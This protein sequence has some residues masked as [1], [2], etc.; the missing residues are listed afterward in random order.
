[1]NEGSVCAEVVHVGQ[2]VPCMVLQVDD[3]KKEG[4]AHKRVWLSLRLSRMY[5]GLSLD[6][7][8]D[9]MVLTAQVKSVEDHGYILYFGVSTFSGFMP[10]AGKETVKIESGQL[11]QCVVKGID[12][13]RSIIH[14]SSDE[15]LISK[16]IIKDLK[17]LS[18]DHLIPGM[19]MSARVHSV[20][21]N[22]VMLSFLTYFTGT[23]DIFNLS[24][25]FPSGNWKDDYSKN[26]KVNARILFV[27][28][29]TRAVGLTLNQ[30]LLRLN[31]PPI[32]VKVGEI[33]DKSR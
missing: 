12:K 17:G 7:I 8:Q 14:L 15:D 30:H 1:D 18:I 20:L 32:N 10:K 33:Y 16:S 2:L 23:A 28:P 11:I 9:G 3:D 29:S 31:V 4:K 25:S 27:D 21:E 6:A 5:K 26:K 22:G 13:A 19:M 24:S